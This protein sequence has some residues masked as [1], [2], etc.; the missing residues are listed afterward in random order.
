VQGKRMIAKQHPSFSCI[1]ETHLS[2]E[3][4]H[5]LRVTWWKNDLPAN[6][7]KMQTS[8]AIAISNKIHSTKIN[9]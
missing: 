1:Q 6:N 7:P 4:R 3:N 2:N 5:Y 8:V 9:Q